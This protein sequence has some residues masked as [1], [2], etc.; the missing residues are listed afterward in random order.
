[1]SIAEKATITQ[2]AEDHGLRA[3]VV[4]ATTVI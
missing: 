2:L 4:Q 3:F 1:M